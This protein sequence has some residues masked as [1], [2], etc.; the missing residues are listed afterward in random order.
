MAHD[1]PTN[2]CC[3]NQGVVKNTSIPESTLCKKHNAVNYHIVREVVAADVMRVGKENTNTN[4]A[5]ALTKLLPYS[6]KKL[7]L[8][9]TSSS[10]RLM[11]NTS[12]GLFEYGQGYY[13]T[14]YP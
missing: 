12:R 13:S 14:R 4:P 2:V 9:L 11:D 5:D 7:L 6:R 8:G 1:G 3:D 10:C